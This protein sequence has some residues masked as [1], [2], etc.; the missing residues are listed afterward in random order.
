MTT[1]SWLEL[2]FIGLLVL[3][4]LYERAMEQGRT[5]FNPF[6]RNV[7]YRL[8]MDRDRDRAKPKDLTEYDHLAQQQLRRLEERRRR[9][10]A[11][12][13]LRRRKSDRHGE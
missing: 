5:P 13:G 12:S 1:G 4:R 7:D 2:A 3:L 8:P 10:N 9:A 6:D 11:D